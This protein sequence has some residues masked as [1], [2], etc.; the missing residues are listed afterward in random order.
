MVM[1]TKRERYKSMQRRVEAEREARR[2]RDR[3]REAARVAA[4]PEPVD[5]SA[6][7]RRF[8]E[9]C[10]A[11]VTPALEQR[12]WAEHATRQINA[13]M[14]AESG[15]ARGALKSVAKQKVQAE[16]ELLTPEERAKWTPKP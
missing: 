7:A 14:R 2:E 15:V 10:A 16:R 13:H 5:D 9:R 1:A 3:K 4:L 11:E 8:A 12:A 6:V